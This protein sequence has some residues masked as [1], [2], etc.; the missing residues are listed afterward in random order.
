M[1]DATPKKRGRPT[2]YQREFGDEA[3]SFK[4]AF[5]AM[6]SYDSERSN[7]NDLYY[8]EGFSIASKTEGVNARETFFTKAGNH[9][10]K[11]ILEQIGRMSLQDG[12]SR[13]ACEEILHAAIKGMEEGYTIKFIEKWIRHGRTTGSFE[14]LEAA[15]N[16]SFTDQEIIDA[17]EY[18]D[19]LVT[20]LQRESK[21]RSATLKDY[22]IDFE[23][24]IEKAERLRD[25]FKSKYESLITQYT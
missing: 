18:L 5:T 12:Y 11:S 24:A 4:T 6:S 19:L 8:M 7:T 17:Y 25:K 13:K 15:S 23:K 3:Q 10:G 22:T 14:A 2:A 20:V 21:D 9:K 1:A 16:F